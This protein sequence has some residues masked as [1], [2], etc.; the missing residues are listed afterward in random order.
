MSV[1]NRYTYT[2]ACDLR[3]ICFYDLSIFNSAENTKRFLLALFFFS[4]NE[5]NDI[6]Y[7][8]RPVFKGLSCTR[9][10]LVGCNNQFFRSEFFPCCKARRITLDR[11]VWF[12]CDKSSCSSKTL[13]L[14]FDDCKMF[15][16]YFRDYH[17][18]IRCPSVGTVIRYN[19]C[20]CFCVCFLDRT[21]L[22]F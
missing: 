17:R 22:I 4:T 11:T 21:N 6:F 8:F 15:R 1:K 14:V 12:Y 19:R 9:N 16:V 5:W 18:Y 7:H 13:F 2:L 20:L 10:C 3:R